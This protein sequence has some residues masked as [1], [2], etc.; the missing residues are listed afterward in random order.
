MKV[1]KFIFSVDFIVL[2]MEED[3]EIPIILRRPFL[4]I[5]GALIDVKNEKLTLNIQDE[6]VSFDIFKTVHLRDRSDTYFSI[7]SMIN[8][9]KDTVD[10]PC[11]YPPPTTSKTDSSFS[12][13]MEVH[14]Q[15]PAPKFKEVNLK[16]KVKKKSK[17]G[18]TKYLSFFRQY[19][20]LEMLDRDQKIKTSR[21]KL[22]EYINGKINAL[23]TTNI[24]KDLG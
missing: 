16:A 7:D 17:N 5:R 23:R 1:D 15:Q 24:L 8:H 10:N 6:Q 19:V 21:K 20:K 22:K 3:Q 18:K 14:D 9:A 2:D 12:L 13:K 11:S 4:A